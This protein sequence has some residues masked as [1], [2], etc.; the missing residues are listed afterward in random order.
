MTRKTTGSVFLKSHSSSF[1]W[2]SIDNGG[3][4]KV[5]HNES[6]TFVIAEYRPF[7][8]ARILR[9]IFHQSSVSNNDAYKTFVPTNHEGE[10][11]DA[12]L[13]GNNCFSQLKENYE[14]HKDKHFTYIFICKLH[15]YISFFSFLFFPFLL[16]GL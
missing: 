4:H 1:L 7:S 9:L 3:I 10:I 15:A 13:I 12:L 6:R 8:H 14:H 11:V 2:F 5:L 16:V